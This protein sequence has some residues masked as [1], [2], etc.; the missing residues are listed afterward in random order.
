LSKWSLTFY[1][2]VEADFIHDSTESLNE[3]PGNALI[4]RPTTYAGSHDRFMVGIRNSRFGF[5]I[6]APEFH[7][8]RASA[9]LEFDALGN[10]PNTATEGQVWTNPAIRVRHYNLKIETP[11]FDI[12]GGQYWSLFG[13]QTFYFPNTV[14]I[15]G[16]PNQL[17]HRDIQFRVSKT[18]K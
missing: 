2:F 17:F 12:L 7:K 15:M 14:E 9:N 1:G 4:A 18:F 3:V 5:R 10:Q 6:R 8:V 11:I 13:W 16:M